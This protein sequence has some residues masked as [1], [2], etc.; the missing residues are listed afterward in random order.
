VLSK[1]ERGFSD[2]MNQS[3]PPQQGC[4]PS[5]VLQE[6]ANWILS[7][8]KPINVF[9]LNPILL[10]QFATLESRVYKLYMQH[11]LS[12]LRSISVPGMHFGSH[13]EKRKDLEERLCCLYLQEQ[14]RQDT[15]VQV[16]QV[17]GHVFSNG[18]DKVFLDAIQLKRN[19]ACL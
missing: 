11:L 5:S 15:M 18:E 16:E 12:T 10:S 2:Q 9:S 3:G 1:E 6:L 4:S 7:L 17:V 19:P 13:M 14:L 8:P